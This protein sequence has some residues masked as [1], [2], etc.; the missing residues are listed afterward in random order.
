MRDD[1]Q[2]RE[3]I[4][5]I[6]AGA[7]GGTIAAGI[8]GPAAGFAVGATAGLVIASVFAVFAV[9][10]R[11][12]Q[13]ITGTA[14]TMLALGLSGTVYHTVYGAGGVAL[15]TPTIGTIAIPG[16]SAIPFI[17]RALFAQPALMDVIFLVA[18]DAAIAAGA[19]GL[20]AMALRAADHIM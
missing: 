15:S 8:A 1:A 18:I 12:D 6:I 10:L 5:A 9:W 2:G 14:I 16:L 19:E 13:I 17:G 7:L 4:G 11:A 20:G 3:L